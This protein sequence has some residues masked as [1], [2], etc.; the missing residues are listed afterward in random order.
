MKNAR[1]TSQKE[2]P[3]EAG[4]LAVLSHRMKASLNITSLHLQPVDTDG[5]ARRHHFLPWAFC[6][7]EV[8]KHCHSL[9]TKEILENGLRTI[10]RD[11]RNGLGRSRAMGST[12]TMKVHVANLNTDKAR[13]LEQ[14]GRLRKY[15]IQ[16]FRKKPITD[17]SVYAFTNAT[18]DK[19]AA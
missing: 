16:H 14:V 15:V 9:G 17:N 2:K 11:N 12:D 19:K 5:K 4:F 10:R 13:D 7:A 8:Q 18:S 1:E 3:Q 6:G